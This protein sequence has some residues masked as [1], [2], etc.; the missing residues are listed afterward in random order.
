MSATRDQNQK[1]AFV[2]SNLYT[3]YQK[4][5]TAASSAVI[6]AAEVSQ[7]SEAAPLAVS[8]PSVSKS[9]ILKMDDLHSSEVK[10]ATYNPAAFIG[11]R[12]ARPQS[13]ALPP[14]KQPTEALSSLKENLKS[15][16]DL[17]SRLRFMLQE[18]EELVK[19]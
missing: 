13:I 12:V 19:K 2:Y 4:G 6:P 14:A 5:K 18:L 9:Q 10:V 17:H 15:L 7:S 8:T 11:K 1:V 3:I 16:N